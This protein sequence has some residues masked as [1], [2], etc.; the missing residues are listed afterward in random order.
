MLCPVGGTGDANGPDCCRPLGRRHFADLGTEWTCSHQRE[1]DKVSGHAMEPVLEELK[2]TE[3]PRLSLLALG[4]V[5][6][7]D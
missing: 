1:S 5:S 3:V 4:S 2:T 6:H 7:G